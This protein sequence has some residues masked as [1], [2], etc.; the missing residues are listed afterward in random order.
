MG[1]RLRNENEM[2]LLRMKRLRTELP[3]LARSLMGRLALCSVVA[4]SLIVP[5]QPQ[6][7]SS[8]TT[9]PSSTG[10]LPQQDRSQTLNQTQERK[11][12]HKGAA[13]NPTAP[14]SEEVTQDL[15]EK[16]ATG[17]EAHNPD[18]ML[19]VFDRDAMDGYL[20]FSDQIAA[21]FQRFDAFRLHYTIEQATGEGA[22]GTGLVDF[23]LEELPST[24][25]IEPILKHDQL[26][27]E[28]VRGKKGWKIVD[29]SPRAFFS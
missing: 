1:R 29:V 15:I 11:T 4:L 8:G 22:K 21:L 5:A 20:N 3:V 16:L 19:S 23:E 13:D 18:R 10:T 7:S 25:N 6:S 17:L 14:F 12:K 26:T 24:G 9:S 2:S 27:F 28:M